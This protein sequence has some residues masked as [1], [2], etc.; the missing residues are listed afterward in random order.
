MSSEMDYHS[1]KFPEC[2]SQGLQKLEEIIKLPSTS[3]LHKLQQQIIEER[4]LNYQYQDPSSGVKS[5]SP[6]EELV[7]V[8]CIAQYL[9][10]I[11]DPATRNSLFITL[12]PA[13]SNEPQTLPQLRTL[14]SLVSLAVA[15]HN[16]AVLDATAVWM[17]QVSCFSVRCC[18]LSFNLNQDFFQSNIETPEH[19]MKALKSLPTATPLFCANL[20]TSLAQVYA[21]VGTN[22]F[23]KEP[24]P[25]LVKIIIYWLKANPFIILTPLTTSLPGIS[26]PMTAVLAISPLSK[27]CI[28]APFFSQNKTL[29]ENE[30][31]T[32]DLY[33]ELH[34]LLLET[35]QNVSAIR[36]QMT[37]REVICAEHIKNIADVL[38]QRFNSCKKFSPGTNARETSLNR[39]AQIV[40][41][42]LHTN[43][44]SGRLSEMWNSLKK[45]PG[46]PR[47][48]KMLFNY[49]M[50]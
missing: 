15:T 12:F 30:V 33:S 29:S 14:M 37:Q 2:I 7:I 18:K 8:R 16:V 48:M 46:T 50:C 21:K 11:F 47:L 41:V 38:V 28:E 19:F 49:N 36:S 13:V 31:E 34:F 9:A 43:C 32:K 23:C 24:E 20:I 35:L 26:L 40:L 10:N 39:L 22:E 5:I 1:S 25:H 17:Q 3:Q 4:I 45:L 6:I 44:L 27:W 42:A